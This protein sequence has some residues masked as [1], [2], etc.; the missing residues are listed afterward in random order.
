MGGNNKEEEKSFI[1]DGNGSVWMVFPIQSDWIYAGKLASVKLMYK[2]WSS[3]Y[4]TIITDFIP[5][6]V[7]MSQSMQCLGQGVKS[8]YIWI[9]LFISAHSISLFIKKMCTVI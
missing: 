8:L 4:V 1:T 7:R 5:A 9:P 3:D 6:G 2:N